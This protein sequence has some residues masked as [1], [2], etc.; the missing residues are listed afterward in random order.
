MLGERNYLGQVLDKSLRKH[1][2]AVA[3]A[4]NTVK[5]FTVGGYYIPKEVG[6]ESNQLF[7]ATNPEIWKN[8]KVFDPKRFANVES[9]PNY[10][11]THFSFSMGPHVCLRQTFAKFE[12]KVILAKLMRRFKFRLLPNQTDRME[13]RLTFT[14]WDG[15]MCDVTRR[16]WI[17]Q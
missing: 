7:F 8:P 9:M 2:V 12:S 11:M 17:K 5:A 1:P 4:R 14:P 16:E 3:P 6:V 10:N 13:A 15:V